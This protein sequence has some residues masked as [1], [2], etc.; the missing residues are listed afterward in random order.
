MHKRFLVI[1]AS[2]GF[3]AVALGA[4]GAHALKEQLS[5]QSL[6]TYE[7]G[8]R[9]QFYHVFAL[10]LTAILFQSFPNKKMVWAGKLFIAGICIFSGSLY[11]LALLNSDQYKWIGA[12]TPFGGLCF[13]LGWISIV[14][15]VLHKDAQ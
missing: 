4:F 1:A 5:T 12:I 13:L 10:A 9:Y 7:T 3:L 15:G 14:R 2:L 11:V 8:V 6:A